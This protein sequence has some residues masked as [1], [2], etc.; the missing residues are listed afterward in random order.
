MKIETA[1]GLSRSRDGTARAPKPGGGPTLRS[2]IFTTH[3]LA[4]TGRDAI[5]PR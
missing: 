3:S 5:R 2:T 1:I 4:A